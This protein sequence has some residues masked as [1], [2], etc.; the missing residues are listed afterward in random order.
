MKGSQ[1]MKRSFISIFGFLAVVCV[2]GRIA[3]A[4]DLTF[5]EV[6]GWKQSG[7][8]QTFDPKTLYE[9]I[10]GAADL[11]LAYDFEKLQIEEYQNEKKASVTIEVYRHK[12]PNDAFGIYSQ[13]RLPE[14]S[15]LDVGTQGYSDKEVLNFFTGRYYVKITG[16][17]IESGEQE[18]MLS[19]AKK[20]A[21]N[22]GGKGAFPSA[23]ASFPAEG[24]M[25]NAIR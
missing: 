12:T 13:E 5:P 2:V 20:V 21:E 6:T 15:Y 22:L 3:E 18:A 1:V 9:Y 16:Y 7:E 14:S 19:F 24:K 8:V 17:K 25:I 11:Y 10:N 4:K 23:L